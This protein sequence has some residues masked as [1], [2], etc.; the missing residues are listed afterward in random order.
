MRVKEVGE[1]N[2]GSHISP[3]NIS[4]KVNELKNKYTDLAIEYEYQFLYD[5]D[6]TGIRN[7]K[8]KSYIKLG[9][10]GDVE[11]FSGGKPLGIHISNKHNSVTTY[12][13]GINLVSSQ[14]RIST[15]QKGL[16]LNNHKLNSLLYEYSDIKNPEYWGGGSVKIGKGYL[17]DLKIPCSVRWRC[18]GVPNL[19]GRREEDDETHSSHWVRKT[20]YITPFYWQREDEEYKEILENLGIPT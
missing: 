17:D 8:T 13:E 6:E 10:T 14:V 4:V 5:K 20:V 15:D 3:S 7:E 16:V 19:C 9:N 2:I 1:G 11:L 18:P 12:G